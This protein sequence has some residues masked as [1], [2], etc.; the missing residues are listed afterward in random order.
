M[1]ARKPTA[2][3]LLAGNPGGHKINKREPKPELKIPDPPRGMTEGALRFWPEVTQLI[4]KMKITTE[5]DKYALSQLCEAFADQEAARLSLSLAGGSVIESVS[6]DGGIRY[7][8]R[9]E[10]KI[11]SDLDRRIKMYLIEFGLTPASR[12]RVQTLDGSEENNGGIED[13]FG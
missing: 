7:Y 11:L 12:Q 9:P 6:K 8:P 3:K 10:V 2:L 4:D 1:T 5:Q 13:Y